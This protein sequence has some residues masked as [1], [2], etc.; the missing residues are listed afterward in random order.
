MSG[1]LMNDVKIPAKLVLVKF[2]NS[3]E[4][5]EYKKINR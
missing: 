5:I 4:W 2:P 3:D 1:T